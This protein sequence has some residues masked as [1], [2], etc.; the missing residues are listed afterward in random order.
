[1]IDIREAIQQAEAISRKY[2][3]EGLAPFPFD[4]IKEGFK[5]LDIISTDELPEDVSG[6]IIYRKDAKK[7]IIF[8]N[9]KKHPN[10]QHFTIAH[11]LGHYFLHKNELSSENILVDADTTLDSNGIFFRLDHAETT[12][13]ETQANNFAATLI[14]PERLV[15]EVWEK[16]NDVEEAAKIF[17]VSLSA[18]S[19]RLE[20]LGLVA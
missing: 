6:A 15:Q 20:K 4:K 19:I 2:N 1:M 9:N 3:P 5:D 13:I 7:Y 10:R 16:L 8:N 17:K 11:E 18:M 14:M 12:K